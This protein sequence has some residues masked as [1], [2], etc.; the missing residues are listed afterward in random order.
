[1]IKAETKQNKQTNNKQKWKTKAWNLRESK[2]Y[3]MVAIV[4]GKGRE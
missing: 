2:G 1:M 3:Y 4:G